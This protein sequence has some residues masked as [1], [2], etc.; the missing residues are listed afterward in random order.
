MKTIPQGLHQAH[1]K[2]FISP[3]IDVRFGIKKGVMWVSVA[4]FVLLI[5]SSLSTLAHKTNDSAFTLFNVSLAPQKR[6]TMV[7]A[8]ASF[9]DDLGAQISNGL[10]EK[11]TTAGTL[12]DAQFTNPAEFASFVQNYLDTDTS[13]YEQSLKQSFAEGISV[14]A[15]IENHATAAEKKHYINTVT[16]LMDPS[17]FPER[18]TTANISS[19]ETFYAHLA[20]QLEQTPV[21]SEYYFIHYEFIRAAK[22]KAAGYDAFV[23]IDSDPVKAAVVMKIFAELDTQTSTAYQALTHMTS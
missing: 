13:D 18:D 22:I 3:T 9:T 2:Y 21:P 7:P 5:L 12:Q 11:I 19:A 14:H 6:T 15:R 20:T 10:S 17:Q 16:A 4:G 8:S 1:G 23:N